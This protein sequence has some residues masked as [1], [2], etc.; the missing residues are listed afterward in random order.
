MAYDPKSLPRSGLCMSSFRGLSQTLEFRGKPVRKAG[1]CVE[2]E[3]KT[4]AL[5]FSDL[6]KIIEQ[7]R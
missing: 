1:R 7:I 5:L 4:Q 3:A 6:L 2:E